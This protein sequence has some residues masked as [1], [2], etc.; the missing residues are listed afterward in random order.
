MAARMMCY[1]ASGE[2]RGGGPSLRS[3]ARN[4]TRDVG[5]LLARVAIVDAAIH[6]AHPLADRRILDLQEVRQIRGAHVE[7]LVRR[8]EQEPQLALGEV[9]M[10]EGRRVAVELL[11]V[12]LGDQRLGL[13]ERRRSETL[14]V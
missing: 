6:A 14:R 1:A 4:G 7:P 11:Q 13:L 5:D 10:A 12:R 9:R 8:A 3:L 2:R